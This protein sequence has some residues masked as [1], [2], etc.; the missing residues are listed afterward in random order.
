MNTIAHFLLYSSLLH[1]LKVH[2]KQTEFE[3][4]LVQINI[5]AEGVRQAAPLAG[6]YVDAVERDV[7]VLSHDKVYTKKLNR[8]FSVLKRDAVALDAEVEQES[9]EEF[10]FLLMQSR[11]CTL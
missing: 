10:M 9:K 2:Q 4:S 7:A 5:A 1:P 6:A 3:N 8:D 11:F